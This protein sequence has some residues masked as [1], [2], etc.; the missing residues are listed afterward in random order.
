[1]TDHGVEVNGGKA[2]GF[3]LPRG[4]VGHEMWYGGNKIFPMGLAEGTVLWQES[5]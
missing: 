1:M 3:L 4:A 2:H 5:Q